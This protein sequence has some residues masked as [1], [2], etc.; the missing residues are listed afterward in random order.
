MGLL[1][2]VWVLSDV[3]CD[4]IERASINRA[5]VASPQREVECSGQILAFPGSH[6]GDGVDEVDGEVVAPKR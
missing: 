3:V 4:H 2:A 6:V 5:G 1:S